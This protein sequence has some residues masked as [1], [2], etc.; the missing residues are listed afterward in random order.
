MKVLMKKCKQKLG[1]LW[2]ISAAV[3]LL[4]LVL[5]IGFG[6]YPDTEIHTDSEQSPDSVQ[7]IDNVQEAWD[8]FIPKIGPILTLIISVWVIDAL[9]KSDRKRVDRFFFRITYAISASYLLLILIVLTTF[10]WIFDDS[11]AIDLLKQSSLWLNFI[12]T[13]V[14]ATI[15]IFFVKSSGQESTNGDGISNPE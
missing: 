8:W 14:I 1:V 11:T 2:L 12:L 5:Q 7:Y 3:L 15:G 10:H 13:L 9:G 6:M 4:I